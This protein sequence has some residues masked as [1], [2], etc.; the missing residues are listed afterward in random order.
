MLR[1]ITILIYIIGCFM[2]FVG[3]NHFTKQREFKLVEVDCSIQWRDTPF[4]Q[5]DEMKCYAFR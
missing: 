4:K 2:V 3:I 5:M 1:P